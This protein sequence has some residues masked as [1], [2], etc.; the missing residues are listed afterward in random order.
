MDELLHPAIIELGEPACRNLAVGLARGLVP[1]L[2]YIY[3]TTGS[4]PFPVFLDSAS[5]EEE[6][7]E[8]QE[9]TGKA[10][11]RS[12]RAGGALFKAFR[13]VETVSA[14]RVD[15]PGERG[16]GRTGKLCRKLPCL[17]GAWIILGRRT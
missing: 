1:R 11:G 3:G 17:P 6:E 2:G 5:R 8:G 12:L 14:V 7:A 16:T 15:F 10:H 9:E 4:G 13:V